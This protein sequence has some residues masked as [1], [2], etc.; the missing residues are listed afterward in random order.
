MKK[1]SVAPSNAATSQAKVFVALSDLYISPSN[2]RKGAV[3][4]IAELAAMIESQSLLCPLQ[5]KEDVLATGKYGVVAGGRRLRALQLLANNGKISNDHLVEC[6]LVNDDMASEVSLAENISQEAMHPADEFTAYQTLVTEGKTAESIAAKFGVSVAH[7]VRRLKMANVSPFLLDLYKANEMTLDQIMALASIDDQERQVNTWNGLPSYNRQ[8]H[9]IKNKLTEDEVAATD[10]RVNFVGIQTYLDAGGEIRT[11][12]FAEGDN[13]FLTDMGLLEMLVSERL[14]LESEAQR[15]EGWLW[16]ET[17]P[18]FGYEERQYYQFPTKRYLAETPEIEVKRL[19]LEADIAALQIKSEAANDAEEYDEAA[20]LDGKIEA[21]ESRIDALR[22][23]L[24][25]TSGHDKTKSGVIVTFDSDGLV[26]MRGMVRTS[27]RKKERRSTAEGANSTTRAEVPEKLMLNLSSHRTAAMQAMMIDNQ[28]VALA[29]LATKMAFSTFGEY[30][31]SPVKISMTHAIHTL[32]KHAPTLSESRAAAAISD[33]R[34]A[35]KERLPEDSK[36]WFDWF[37][38]QKQAVAIGMIVFTTASCTEA[39]QGRCDGVD[40]GKQIASALG[41]NMADWWEPTPE[42]YLDLV[43]KTKLIEMVLEV[44][45]HVESEVMAKMK[46]PDAIEHA[47]TH[48]QGSR[49]L[50]T[51]LRSVGV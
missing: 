17:L 36:E 39:L 29:A 45:G 20:E 43:P 27:D 30:K 38:N 18:A 51:P 4:G 8:P 24:L 13:R 9:N 28:H 47:M 5:V 49:W 48:M 22:E 16:V 3:S 40:G 34:S 7:V 2:V 50:P 44:A 19:G 46:K 37:L 1:Q 42:T 41:L 15:E 31:D 32:E 10:K 25:D 14:E 6:G 35:W 26:I 21:I 33:E 11:D 12:L 23:S